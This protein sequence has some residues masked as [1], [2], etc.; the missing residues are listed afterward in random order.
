M[1]K[2]DVEG[3]LIASEA[4]TFLILDACLVYRKTDEGH[5]LTC[6]RNTIRSSRRNEET[7]V[8]VILDSEGHW[9]LS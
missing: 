6:W 8:E 4:G 7:L 9:S 5:W 1:D 2:E 3:M